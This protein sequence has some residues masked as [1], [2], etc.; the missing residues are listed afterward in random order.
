M[1]RNFVRGQSIRQGPPGTAAPVGRGTP[2]GV[3]RHESFRPIGRWRLN[4]EYS[5][6]GGTLA[7][8]FPEPDCWGPAS[9]AEAIPLPKAKPRALREHFVVPSIRRGDVACAEWPNIRRF[10]HFP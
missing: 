4:L 6:A 2:I 5:N 3:R 7:L 1:S 8:G 10:E 9:A